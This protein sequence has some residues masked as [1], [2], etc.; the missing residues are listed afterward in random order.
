MEVCVCVLGQ[1]D[2]ELAM[3]ASHQGW[4]STFPRPLQPFHPSP[5]AHTLMGYRGEKKRFEDLSSQRWSDGRTATSREQLAAIKAI[6]ATGRQHVVLW[7]WIINMAGRAAL[8]HLNPHSYI[9]K[10]T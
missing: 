9:S 10:R 1:D 3:I 2:R 7:D 6:S 8:G 4:F 5:S